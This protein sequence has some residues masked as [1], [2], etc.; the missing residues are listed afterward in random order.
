MDQNKFVKKFAIKTDNELKE[1][2]A[3]KITYVE[4]ARNAALQ[5]LDKRKLNPIKTEIMENVLNNNLTENTSQE[6]FSSIPDIKKASKGKR[7]TNYLIDYIFM[8]II[9][10][11]FFV[12]YAFLIEFTGGDTSYIDSEEFGEGFIYNIVFILY[13]VL[14]YFICENFF[15]GK[16]IGKVITNTKAISKDGKALTPKVAIKRSL[17]R[18]IPFEAFS[19]L[20]DIDNAWHDKFSNTIVVIDDLTNYEQL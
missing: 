5:L 15:N 2:V 19:F 9:A 8:I 3:D 4:D 12:L 1:I 6:F 7:F 13:M 17:I 20:G 16:T 10:I 11:G 14:Y 18:I